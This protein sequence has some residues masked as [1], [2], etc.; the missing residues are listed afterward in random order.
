MAEEFKESQFNEAA[1]KMKRIHEAQAMINEHRLRP[2]E[3]SKRFP[4]SY[5]FEVSKA[6]ILNLFAEAS[7]KLTPNEIES[8]IKLKLKTE[9][10]MSNLFEIPED[11]WEYNSK[12]KREIID[13]LFEFELS[14]RKGL[15]DHG[16]GSP[17]KEAEAGWD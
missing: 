4:N 11:N 2:F 14:S 1:L 3:K 15:E 7:T 6:E 8:L 16:Y 13:I 9:K 10:L 17:N 5:G 12:L